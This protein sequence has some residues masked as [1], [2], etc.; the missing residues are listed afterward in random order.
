[1]YLS[2]L[3]AL[4]SGFFFSLMRALLRKTWAAAAMLVLFG[5]AV[6]FPSGE[7]ALYLIPTLLVTGI[8]AFVIFR[9]GLLAALMESLFFVLLLCFPITTDLSAWYSGIGLTG[10]TLLLAFAL[11]A[12]HTSLGS[13]PLFGRAS[14]ED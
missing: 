14:L 11:Y 5:T 2:S 1:M 13:Q 10:L 8:S 4:F 9:F 6:I 7:S 12:F 3:F